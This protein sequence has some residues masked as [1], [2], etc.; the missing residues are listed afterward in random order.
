MKSVIET[1]KDILSS[2]NL[3]DEF[4]GVHIDYTEPGS[5]VAGLFS[6]GATKI[7]EDIIGNPTY[8]ISFQ[9]YTG[10]HAAMDYDR[11]RNSEFLLHLTYYLDRQR[12]IPITETVEGT[13]YGG[14]ITKMTCG[15]ALL[16]QVP[17]GDLNDGVT[18]QLQI[19]ADYKIE[20]D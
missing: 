6:N 1:V 15:N 14:E 4:N 10:M 7:G 3:L 13:E 11:L 16:Y 5:D 8:Q 18:Y 9:L 12:N 20:M 17:T 2:C 19:T